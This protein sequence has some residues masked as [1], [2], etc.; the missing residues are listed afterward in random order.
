[1]YQPMIQIDANTYLYVT[2]WAIERYNLFERLREIDR[3]LDLVS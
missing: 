1:M 3:E 2:K